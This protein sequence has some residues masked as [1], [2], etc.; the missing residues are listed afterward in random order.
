[1]GVAQGHDLLV[2]ESET[3]CIMWYVFIIIVNR[4]VLKTHCYGTR[5]ANLIVCMVTLE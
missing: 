3:L 2:L 5:M 4:V 1:M